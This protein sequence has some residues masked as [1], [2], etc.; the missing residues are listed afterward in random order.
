L[1]D[2]TKKTVSKKIGEIENMLA[3]QLFVR[4]HRSTIINI[5]QFKE[6]VKGKNNFLLYFKTLAIPIEISR[7]AV[8]FIKSLY[9]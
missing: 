5:Q 7:S 2:N 4:I 9:V 1:V 6:I 3:N 8:Q